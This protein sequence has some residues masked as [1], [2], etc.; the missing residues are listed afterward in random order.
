M[1]KMLHSAP[2]QATLPDCF[3]FPADKRPPATAAAVSLPIIDLS[4]S[5]DEVRRAILDAGKEIGFFQARPPNSPPLLLS[6]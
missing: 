6:L 2:I 1:E 3:I 5:R 4:R